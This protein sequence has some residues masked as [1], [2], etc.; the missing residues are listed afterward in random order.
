MS[1]ERFDIDTGYRDPLERPQAFADDLPSPSE[2]Y[3]DTG[4]DPT[5]C[6]FCGGLLDEERPWR[7]GRDGAGA[8]EE[9]LE[10]YS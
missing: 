4:G 7:R 2:L 3:E 6:E 9:C 10:A 1:D 8:H 5:R